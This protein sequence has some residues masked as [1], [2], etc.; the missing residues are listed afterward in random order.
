M[1]TFTNGR[2]LHWIVEFHSKRLFSALE[3]LLLALF[4]LFSLEFFSYH[5]YFSNKIIPGVSLAKPEANLNMSGKT[6]GQAYEAI[7]KDFA[8][9]SGEPLSIKIGDSRILATLTELGIDLEATKSARSLY[10]IGRSRNLLSDLV[11][12]YKSMFLGVTVL[13][14]YSIDESK[15][16]V[17]LTRLSSQLATSDA[18]FTVRNG[19]FV[20]LPS[21]EGLSFSVKTLAGGILGSVRSLNREVVIDAAQ[22]RPNISTSDLEILR[23]KLTSLYLSKPVFYYGDK[24]WTISD[25]E[26]PKVFDL[27]KSTPEHPTVLSENVAAFSARI[28]QEI[29]IAPRAISFQATG[30]KISSFEGGADG[31]AVDQPVFQTLIAENIAAGSAAKVLIPINRIHPEIGANEYGVKELIGEGTSNFAGSIPGRRHNIQISST[32]LNG[33]LIPPGKIFSFNEAV[34]EVSARTGYDYAYIISEGR[35][36]LGTGGGL[37]Q[38]S[39][40][41]FRAALNSG[42]PILKRT[43]HAYRVHYYEEGGSPVGFD[44][45]VFSPSVDLQF[46]NNTGNYILVQSVFE[47]EKDSLI[48]RFYGTKDG[49]TVKIDGPVILSSSPAPAPLYQDDPTLPK[50]TV[51]QIDFAAGGMSVYFKRLV[52]RNGEKLADDTFY[53]RY[54][55]WQAIYLVGTS[56]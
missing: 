29:D 17:F 14:D 28:A 47:N 5:L 46:E 48:F 39:T 56:E 50:G 45:T 19:Q 30:D 42:L 35:T 15:F 41:V 2:K 22:T 27:M 36:V 32:K 4:F 7:E 51:K 3:K 21:K 33:A 54:Q 1:T 12:E 11:T 38:V 53:S 40:T 8:A 25:E 9:F 44:S 55:P 52:E 13:P 18:A 10:L 31:F 23:S 16:N 24:T 26:F 49:R 6:Y 34:G 37:C 43:A 20:V